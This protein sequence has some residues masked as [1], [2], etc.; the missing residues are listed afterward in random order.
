MGDFLKKLISLLITIIFVAV[1]FVSLCSCGANKQN[2][3][4]A[5]AYSN[6]AM[7]N[8]KT[9][10]SSFVDAMRKQNFEEAESYVINYTTMGFDGIEDVSHDSVD[11]Q[12]YKMLFDSYKVE[13][14]DSSTEDVISPYESE[15]LFVNGRKA[16]ITFTFTSFNYGKMMEDLS[17]AISDVGGERMYYGETFETQEEA[18]VLVD[19]AFDIVLENDPSKYYTQKEITLD[20]WYN[21]GEWKLEISDEFYSALVGR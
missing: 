19:D 11:W 18:L 21:D 4:V 10:L 1:L 20:A 5:P 13:Y 8:P 9:T 2:G 15:D 6:S 16:A 7:A 14:K 17:A 12:I 3:N